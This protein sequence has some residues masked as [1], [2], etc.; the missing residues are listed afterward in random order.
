M[1][2]KNHTHTGLSCLMNG[3]RRCIF[4]SLIT[5]RKGVVMVTCKCYRRGTQ[6][7]LC[8]EIS[9]AHTNTHTH[10]QHISTLEKLWCWFIVTETLKHADW[11]KSLNN[12]LIWSVSVWM[13]SCMH[14]FYIAMCFLFIVHSQPWS[15]LCIH[16]RLTKNSTIM[17]TEYT[18]KSIT[19]T[20]MH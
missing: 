1:H 20:N 11:G 6:R 17:V 8:G 15:H 18:L 16:L 7:T 5:E 13:E 12:W 14:C 4:L 9:S 2:W 10:T 3:M 19:N